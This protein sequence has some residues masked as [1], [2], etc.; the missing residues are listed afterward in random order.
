[1]YFHKSLEKECS[2]LLKWPQTV[3]IQMSYQQVNG[4]ANHSTHIHV[5]GTLRSK[6]ERILA[7]QNTDSQSHAEQRKP[8]TKGNA[9]WTSI[10]TGMLDQAQ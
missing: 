9:V 3:T 2:L 4:T 7:A 10:Y 6:T 1:M 8:D 5:T